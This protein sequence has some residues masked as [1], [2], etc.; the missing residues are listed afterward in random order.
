MLNRN[1]NAPKQL[2]LKL[3]PTLFSPSEMLHCLILMQPLSLEDAVE[4]PLG[5]FLISTERKII[6]SYVHLDFS[7]D[8]M[9]LLPKSPICFFDGLDFMNELSDLGQFVIADSAISLD[10]FLINMGFDDLAKQLKEALDQEISKALREMGLSIIPKHYNFMAE[11]AVMS[12][13]RA[14]RIQAFKD[15]PILLIPIISP[16]DDMTEKH[17]NPC[18]LFTDLLVSGL[19]IE[20]ALIEAFKVDDALLM[21]IKAKRFWDVDE[22]DYI[23]LEEFGK[24]MAV[25]QHLSQPKFEILKGV[26]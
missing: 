25:Y 5:I 2:S 10:Q 9:D 26:H 23:V 18:R 13:Q 3:T 19:T 15:Y 8:L 7:V 16:T 11:P 24:E 17:G 14:L 20:A 4:N 21:A 1:Q 12:E 22:D 6:Q